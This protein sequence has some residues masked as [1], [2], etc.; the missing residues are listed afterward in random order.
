MSFHAFGIPLFS[1][2][3]LIRSHLVNAVASLL[4]VL[5]T[6]SIALKKIINPVKAPIHDRPRNRPLSITNPH[7]SSW[8]RVT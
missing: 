8:H 6:S 4:D 3:T 2:S 5:V 7:V 1:Y